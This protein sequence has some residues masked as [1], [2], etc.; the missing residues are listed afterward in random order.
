LPERFYA[1]LNGLLPGVVDRALA[2]QLPTIFRY[3]SRRTHPTGPDT[4][5]PTRA[6][7]T[8]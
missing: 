4:D 6:M 8:H 3:L 5:A 7:E 1:M 2:R